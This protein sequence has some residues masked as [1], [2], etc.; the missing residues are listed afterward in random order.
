MKLIYFRDLHHGNFGD[1]FNAWMWPKLLDNF[2]DENEDIIF[3]GIGSIIGKK[4][5]D[6]LDY[7]PGQKKV[8][9]GSG[10]V[11]G[12]HDK[13]DLL[14]GSWDVFFVRGPRTARA[15]GLNENLAI[16]DSAILLRSLIDCSGPSATGPIGYVPHWESMERGNWENVCEKAGLKLIDPR[17]TVD[18]VLKQL[19][20]CRL[21]VTEA[22]HGAIV[23]DALRIP[24]IAVE[25]HEK[26]HKEKW[27]DWA[28]A[29]KIT[30][31]C[32]YLPPSTINEFRTKI[33]HKKVL[34]LFVYA[35][36]KSPLAFLLNKY[37]TARAAK[38][39][40]EISQ[41]PT[42]LSSDEAISAATHAML[43]KLTQ[44]KSTYGKVK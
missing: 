23:S 5:P 17:G 24:W 34:H 40:K 22:M 36:C 25:P 37:L 15:F 42:S 13:P 12:Y 33:R 20:A 19:K 4:R 14:D 35:L 18:E 6:H 21:V 26:K 1:D 41:L 3:V 32:Y 44:L 10:Y 31:Y 27:F 9:F 38:K 16:G 2:F 43:E 39:I 28:E 29:L 11:A 30:L 7:E 8:V